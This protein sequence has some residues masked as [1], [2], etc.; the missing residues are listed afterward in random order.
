MSQNIIL[1]NVVKCRKKY[2]ENCSF[3]LM[4]LQSMYNLTCRNFILS[5][6][7]RFDKSSF[8]QTRSAEGFN[9]RLT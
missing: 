9:T 6:Y 8:W 3:K 5:L 2:Y 1:I 7:S 4:L